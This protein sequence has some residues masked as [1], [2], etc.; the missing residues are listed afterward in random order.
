MKIKTFVV[1]APIASILGGLL[2][3]CDGGGELSATSIPDNPVIIT[4]SNYLE[5]AAV[6]YAG[7]GSFLELGSISEGFVTPASVTDSSAASPEQGLLPLTLD[8]ARPHL[9]PAGEVMLQ[10]AAITPCPEGGTVTDALTDRDGSGNLSVGDTLT[11]DTLVG[12]P[13]QYIGDWSVSMRVSYS[14]LS[15][16]DALQSVTVNG[17]V[18]I[19]A[20]YDYATN[21]ET[22][23]LAGSSL[24]AS[25]SGSLGEEIARWT[26]FSFALALDYN[27]QTHAEDGD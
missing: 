24:T 10:A 6:A 12:D 5:V 27:Q 3:G 18:G 16:S 17:D 8:L 21:I 2:H 25:S 20:S 13:S 15:I 23:S 4:S 11:L 14:S 9:F 19:A 26:S 7:I 1:L 22:G